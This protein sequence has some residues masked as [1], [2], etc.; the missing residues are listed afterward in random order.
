M[1]GF[2][3]ENG[4]PIEVPWLSC[5]ESHT[6]IQRYNAILSGL[7]NFYLGYVRNR[8]SIHRWIYIIRF[9]CLKTLA[10][11]YRTS[12]RGIFRKY[13][14]RMHS[15]SL[16]TVK[17]IARIKMDTET[18]ERSYTLY[19]YKDLVRSNKNQKSKKDK[20]QRF[21]DSRKD[22]VIGGYPYLGS[23]LPTVTNDDYLKK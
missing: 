10:Q 18:Y 13:G 8:A 9:S 22:T 3:N 7:A 14:H 15:K 1:K 12:I 4:I 23:N 17:F 19:S 21:Y 20:Q 6:I 2:C 5:L 11:K 16:Q